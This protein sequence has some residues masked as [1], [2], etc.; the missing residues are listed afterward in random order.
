MIFGIGTDIVKIQRIES[1]LGRWGDAFAQRILHK[2]EFVEYEKIARPA[3]FLAKR[4]A[5][6]EATAKA[7]GT[8]F[9][10][11]LI[12]SNIE[13]GHDS[14]G[15]PTLLFHGKASELIEKFHIVASHLSISD[16]Q[17]YV[18]AYVVLETKVETRVETRAE[19]RVEPSGSRIEKR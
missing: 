17:D 8:G 12:L 19:T 13:I 16:E 11:G 4:F 5:A 15:K 14:L 3:N 7:L 6:K 2:Q 9:R 18:I 10:Q 1:G